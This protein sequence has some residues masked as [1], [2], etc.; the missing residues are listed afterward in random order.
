MHMAFISL[1]CVV[2]TLSPDSKGPRIN[3][4]E[5]RSDAKMLTLIPPRAFAIWV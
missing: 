2:V 4:D 3:V 1:F 5:Y